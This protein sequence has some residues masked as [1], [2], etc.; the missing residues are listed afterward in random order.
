MKTAVTLLLL[1]LICCLHQC[2]AAPIGPCAL[3][4]SCCHNVMKSG[5]EKAIPAKKVKII[6]TTPSCCTIEA[7]LVTTVLDKMFCVAPDSTWAKKVGK[8]LELQ[9]NQTS[10]HGGPKPGV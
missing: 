3:Q 7:L 6:T 2:A 8:H 4:G 10:K 9:A 5:D 1:P